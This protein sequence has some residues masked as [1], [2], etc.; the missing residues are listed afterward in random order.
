MMAP[1]QPTVD[2][3]L[4][5]L[6][7]GMP[8]RVRG[9]PEYQTIGDDAVW[10]HG[11]LADPAPLRREL[12][13]GQSASFAQ[14]VG[15]GW[16]SW[17]AE[18]TQRIAGEYAAV[19]VTGSRAVLIGDRMGLRPLYVASGTESAVVS[20]DLAV[21]ARETGAWRDLDEDYLADMFATGM[22][23]GGRTPYRSIRRLRIG[24]HATWQAGRLRVAGGW[25]PPSQPLAGTFGEHQELLR[26]T[27]DAAV[28]G[29]LPAEGA[30]AVELS[31]GLDTSTVLAVAAG[32]GPTHALSFVHPGHPGSDE[33]PWMRA[34]LATT[35]AQWHP[36]DASQRGTFADGPELG[37][38]LPAPSRRILNWAS[39]AAEESIARE[40]GVSAIL[41]GEGGDAVFFAGLLPW[42]LADLLRTGRL[43]ELRRESIRWGSDGP[44]RRSAAFW[45]R[46]GAF[47]GLRQWR[48]GRT[49]TL[50][51]PGALAESAPW[52]HPAYLR[53]HRLQDRTT[54]T[55]GLRAR[56]VHGQ[57]VVENIVRCVEFARSRYLFPCA[58]VEWRYPLLAPSMVDL[59][60]STPWRIAA[61]PRID[62]A[63]QRYAFNGLVSE[64]I[65]RRRS[66]SVSDEAILHGFERHPRWRDYLG[67]SPHVVARGYVD[68]QAWRA[69]LGSVGRVRR[70][71]QF[72]SAIQVEVWLRH[73][74]YAGAPALL[75]DS[76]AGPIS[77]LRTNT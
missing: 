73:L 13:L 27:V 10:F 46:Q 59:A 64:T 21:L 55:T 75:T 20:T 11:Y 2:G 58:G 45:T 53:S 3:F 7:A 25:Q 54:R 6:P 68:P 5:F 70:L 51:P 44:L 50:E 26:A 52:L 28:A 33:T 47:G 74:Q 56:S 9:W 17:G 43:T 1:A 57:A 76:R 8:Q 42:Y 71:P 48:A 41:T 39:N 22:H 65:L 62:R 23:L 29:A 19:V 31:G 60:L 15:A 30:Q 36:I 61:D 16:R 40:L 63:V 24:E 4:V 69:A 49:L 72:Y 32:R 77:T 66:K 12:T 34:A 67:D 35:A 37:I 18:I 38:F 14:I